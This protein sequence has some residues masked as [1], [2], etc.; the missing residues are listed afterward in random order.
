MLRSSKAQSPRQW[1]FP[2]LLRVMRMQDDAAG[3][4]GPIGALPL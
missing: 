2:F 1:D 3:R 4:S